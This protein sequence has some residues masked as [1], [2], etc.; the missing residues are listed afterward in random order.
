[1]HNVLFAY[2]VQQKPGVVFDQKYY[3][4]Y[5][6]FVMALKKKLSYFVPVLPGFALDI[7]EEQTKSIQR[8]QS[9]QYYWHHPKVLAM[10]VKKIAGKLVLPP[11]YFHNACRRRNRRDFDIHMSNRVGS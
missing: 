9:C 8:Y 7:Q 11:L 5:Y 10:H 1:M 4:K 2:R 3:Q 6:P